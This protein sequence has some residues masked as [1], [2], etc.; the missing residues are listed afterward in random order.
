MTRFEE[1]TGVFGQEDE[2][3]VVEE[4]RT[5]QV[6]IVMLAGWMLRRVE[7]SSTPLKG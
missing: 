2:R 5:S 6:V 4:T 1:G 7:L 3:L